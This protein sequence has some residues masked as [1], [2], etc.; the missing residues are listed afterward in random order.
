MKLSVKTT[1]GVKLEAGQSERIIF[2]DDIKGFG[3]RL[4]DGGSRTWIYQ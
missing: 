4:R 2:D 3:L 1:G